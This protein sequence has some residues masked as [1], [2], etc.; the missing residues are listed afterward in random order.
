MIIMENISMINI[1]MTMQR[2]TMSQNTTT[3]MV[4]KRMSITRTLL[5]LTT[6]NRSLK[7]IKTP[8]IHLPLIKKNT[9]NL[10]MLVQQSKQPSINII[11]RQIMLLTLSLLRRYITMNQLTSLRR[12]SIIP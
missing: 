9:M 3:T 10:I 4:N 5:K 6:K 2:S 8:N 12:P 7:T 1:K 11:L